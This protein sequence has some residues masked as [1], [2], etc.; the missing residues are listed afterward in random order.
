M[1]ACLPLIAKD[2]NVRQKAYCI[3]TNDKCKN[4]PPVGLLTAEANHKLNTNVTSL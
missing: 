3:P 2:D 4:N 1:I